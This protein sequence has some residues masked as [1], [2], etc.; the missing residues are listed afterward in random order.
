[1]DTCCSV[2][3]SSFCKLVARLSPK[4]AGESLMEALVQSLRRMTRRSGMILLQLERMIWP[5]D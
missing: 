5:A 4:Q 2:A 1:M 3:S